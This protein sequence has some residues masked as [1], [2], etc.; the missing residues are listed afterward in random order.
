MAKAATKTDGANLQGSIKVLRGRQSWMN[1]LMMGG[2]TTP[3]TAE[4]QKA[5]LM[6][7]GLRTN[8]AHFAG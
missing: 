3:T 4:T 8:A 5:L 7:H 2:A 1:E 6:D